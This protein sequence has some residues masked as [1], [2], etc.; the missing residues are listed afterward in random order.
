MHNGIDSNI[1]S[2][3][4][5]IPLFNI[6]IQKNSR[7]N[8]KHSLPT[9]YFTYNSY[10]T[11]WFVRGISLKKTNTPITCYYALQK[12]KKNQTSATHKHLLLNNILHLLSMFVQQL[13]KLLPNFLFIQQN[14]PKKTKTKTKKQNPN[15]KKTHPPLST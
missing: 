9:S 2:S 11:R 6:S 7:T 8:K 13:H 4:L 5:N 12:K 15:R 1:N 10:S 14:P 3:H